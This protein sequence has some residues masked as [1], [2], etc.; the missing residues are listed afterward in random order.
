MEEL[1]TSCPSLSRPRS[2]PPPPSPLV[3]VS[4]I[5]EPPPLPLL[6]LLPPLARLPPDDFSRPVG[7]PRRFF[8]SAAEERE[9]G[10]CVG[11]YFSNERV[12]KGGSKI[13]R[14]ETLVRASNIF[15]NVAKKGCRLQINASIMHRPY[16]VGGGG[17]GVRFMASP[18]SRYQ[19]HR[20][21]GRAQNKR[22]VSKAKACLN[23][24]GYCGV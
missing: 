14:L 20:R 18:T 23:R 17:G 11:A 19:R 6:L 12:A 5:P 9:K 2:L 8:C 15:L 24:A 4:V 3:R 21:V 22:A 1:R 16:S 10:G 7:E 13:K